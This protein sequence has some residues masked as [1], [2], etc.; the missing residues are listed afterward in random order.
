MMSP[1]GHDYGD[2]GDMPSRPMTG[3]GQDLRTARES[4]GWRLPDVASQLRIRLVYLEAIE[5]GRIAE[6]PGNAYALGFIRAYAQ[7]MGLDADEIAR[8]FRAEAADVNRKTELTFPAPVPERGVP[9]GAMILLSVVLIVVAYMG[10]YRFSGERRPA[11]DAV[12]VVPDRM[13]ALI[14]PPPRP[15][16]A[17]SPSAAQAAPAMTPS[18]VP[19]AMAPSAMAPLAAA[20]PP[21][22]AVAALPTATTP[23][24]A[25]LPQPAQ[26]ASVPPQPP[27]ADG[28]RIV[29]RAK[30]EAWVQVRDTK[31]N[32]VFNRTMRPGETWA[33]P[34]PVPGRQTLLLTLGN[35]GGTEL[36]VDGQVT[37]SLGADGVVRRDIPLDAD[38][39]RDGKLA[40]PPAVAAKLPAPKQP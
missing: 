9:A 13:V 21:G 39:L 27:A 2:D 31:G 35:A 38:Q 17:A 6:L 22:A 28:G 30:A 37:P 33:V 34:G 29:V 3:V 40:V 10:W 15:P 26:P 32:V 11:E 25:S 8:R 12:P 18:V 14:E 1:V 16:V 7:A 19:P 24:P 23:Q 20:R 5:A 36:L 4:L